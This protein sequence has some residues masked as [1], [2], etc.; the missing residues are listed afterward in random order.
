MFND[1]FGKSLSIFNRQPKVSV[2]KDS[3]AKS[4]GLLTGWSI[5]KVGCRRT[6]G[7]NIDN[8]DLTLKPSEPLFYSGEGHLMTIA[9][10][11]AG[12]GVSSIIPALLTYPGSVIVI[13]PKGENYAV[14][15]RRRREMGQR[16]VLLDP[17][18]MTG[19]NCYD[20][21]NP[22]DLIDIKKSGV[23]DDAA[24]LAE[25]IVTNWKSDRYPFFENITRQLITGMILFIAEQFPKASRNIGEIRF[26]LNQI[27]KAMSVMLHGMRL[28]KLEEVK[29]ASRILT[30][31]EPKVRASIIST[32][33]CH[34]G[35]LRGGQTLEATNHSTL[36]I[37]DVTNGEPLSIYIVIPPDKLESHSQLL[38]LWIGTLMSA[39]I[40][41][42]EPA[43]SQTLFI[44]D[45]AAQLGPLD[46]LRQAVTLLRGYGVQTWSFWQDMSQLKRLYPNDWETIYNNCRVHQSFG[47]T[48]LQAAKSA[49]KISGYDGYEELLSMDINQMLLTLPG[50]YPAIAKQPNYLEDE[51]FKGMF[52]KNP[53][54][55]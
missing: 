55:K 5:P 20:S 17:M 41:R 6:I 50:S 46:Q 1:D 23:E 10:T 32:A 33:Q 2:D 38:R 19:A 18:K 11:G 12:K 15:A 48:N 8:S 7:F 37:N 3:S 31:A 35:F 54:Y 30:K 36:D 9:P 40:R 29:Y 21:L 26:Q 22:L 51:C 52:D 44:L 34:L 53:F 49:A 45:E 42:R 43:K 47:F 39:I 28:S 14:T 25:L 4:Q 27:E 13:D 24:T 16:V